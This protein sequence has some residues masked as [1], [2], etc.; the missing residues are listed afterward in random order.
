MLSMPFFGFI[1]DIFNRTKV[2][3]A[4]SFAI[5]FLVI[6]VLLMMSG[7]TTIQ[8][9]VALTFL[10]ILAGS[11]SG[12]S[13]L[14]VISLFKPEE[15]F[16]G[17]AFSYNF[18]IALFGGTSAIISRYLVE[19]TG[20]FYAPGFYIILTTAMFLIALFSITNVKEK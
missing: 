17:V 7:D 8:H 18:G 2:I 14:F 20:L 4:S 11:I 6:P 16:S 10:G 9:L 19:R 1:S 15:R 3:I 5:L 12:V 13:Y